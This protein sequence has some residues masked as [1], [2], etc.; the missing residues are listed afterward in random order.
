MTQAQQVPPADSVSAV[1]RRVFESSKYEWDAPRD[2]FGFV[3]DLYE[4]LVLWLDS[5]RDA[6]PVVYGVLAVLLTAVLVAILV[7]FAYLLWRALKPRALPGAA[8]A[9]LAPRRRN[10]A[11]Y[12]EAARRLAEEGRCADAMAHRFTALVLQ[13]EAD[14]ALKFHPSKTPAEYALEARLDGSA[15]S[16]FTELVAVLYQHLFGGVQCAPSDFVNF[17]RR[18]G[19][20]A[21][22]RA[23]D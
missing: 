13:L 6:H 20:L 16:G 15:H 5:L 1:L 21:V 11:W 18:A 3:R 9:A 19:E 14:E 4:S 8:G 7:H 17:E 10:A 23:A 12:L 22:Q 2:P